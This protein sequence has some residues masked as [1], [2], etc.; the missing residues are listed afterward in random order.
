MDHG[1]G[2]EGGG[3]GADA[4]E[5]S[6]R[7]AGIAHVA[8]HGLDH[9]RQ[10][11]ERRRLVGPRDEHAH[12]TAV[13]QGAHEVLA[14]PAGGAGDDHGLGRFEIAHAS[15]SSYSRTARRCGGR[16]S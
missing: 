7:R 6:V 14:Q 12:A 8:D 2:V 13:G 5:Q 16:R 11:L 4:V 15:I 10:D 3:V 9:R 1:G